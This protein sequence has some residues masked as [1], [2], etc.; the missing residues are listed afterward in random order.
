MCN[1]L[2]YRNLP[3]F[4]ELFATLQ[5]LHSGDNNFNNNKSNTDI[6]LNTE[7]T[8]CCTLPH[9]RGSTYVCTYELMRVSVGQSRTL[10]G[11]KQQTEKQPKTKPHEN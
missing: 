8:A 10:T 2:S 1:I 9:T 5:L 3:T 4:T 6:V 7:I 11:N